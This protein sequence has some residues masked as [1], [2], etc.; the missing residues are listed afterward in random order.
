MLCC[1]RYTPTKKIIHTKE[2]KIVHAKRHS[3]AYFPRTTQVVHEASF[4]KE[5]SHQIEGALYDLRGSC[6]SHAC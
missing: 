2:K 6:L 3:E 1:R 4:F 5:A